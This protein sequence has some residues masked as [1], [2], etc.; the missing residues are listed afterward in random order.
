[1]SARGTAKLAAERWRRSR[2]MVATARSWQ[3]RRGNGLPVSDHPDA[4]E[5]LEVQPTRTAAVSEPNDGGAGGTPQPEAPPSDPLDGDGDP[6]R[7]A[8]AGH[9][10]RDQPSDGWAWGPPGSR[11]SKERWPFTIP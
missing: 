9:L 8:V 11:R 1:M 2:S 5:D 4:G 10:G 3:P 6:W 7:D